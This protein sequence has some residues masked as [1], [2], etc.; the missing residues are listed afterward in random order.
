[1]LH[2][3]DPES[4][5]T[6]VI[7]ADGT[8]YKDASLSLSNTLQIHTG[9]V[10]IEFSRCDC[11][12]TMPSANKGTLHRISSQ[13]TVVY[14]PSLDQSTLHH[15]QSFFNPL[16]P[17][18][19]SFQSVSRSQLECM[20]WLETLMIDTK[21]R[22]KKKLG[23]P[24][25]SSLG[26]GDLCLDLPL[27]NTQNG[28][29]QRLPVPTAISS[30]VSSKSK[31]INSIKDPTVELHPLNSNELSKDASSV[32]EKERQCMECN[33]R[34][35]PLWR[36]GPMGTG[37]L[38]N[39]CGVKWNKQLK[40][41]HTGGNS[42]STNENANDSNAVRKYSAVSNSSLL[43]DD[44]QGQHKIG[45]QERR[46]SVV[47]EVESNL[48]LDNTTKDHVI[49][50]QKPRGTNFIAPLKKRKVILD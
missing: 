11:F 9:Q 45:V 49:I 28:T 34:H 42:T 1:M 46:S 12:T 17:H 33:R 32:E 43:G 35:T 13:A 19:S 24:R 36:K 47:S 14:L 26:I 25:K 41:Q 22:P 21:G 16:F 39:A 50:D 5:C 4:K 44:N 29:N 31:P 2:S 8:L 38:C 27:T 10:S 3:N 30:N 20:Y 18:P 15:L 23:R 7:A 48:V 6:T 37:T 40:Q